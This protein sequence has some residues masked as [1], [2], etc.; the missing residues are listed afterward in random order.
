MFQTLPPTGVGS[1]GASGSALTRTR[2]PATE[3]DDVTTQPDLFRPMCATVRGRQ[4]ELFDRADPP[5]C[6]LS[7]GECGRGMVRTA[8]GYLSCRWRTG[9]CLPR[10]GRTRS[11]PTS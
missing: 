7:C 2:R 6:G 5:P 11:R 10:A 8:S 3:G 1:A 4:G 9:N